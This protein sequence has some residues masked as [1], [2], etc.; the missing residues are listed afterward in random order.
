VFVSQFRFVQ[1][2]FYQLLHQGTVVPAD[3]IGVCRSQTPRTIVPTGKWSVSNHDEL[4]SNFFAQPDALACGLSEE[5][6][7][8]DIPAGLRPHK[9]FPGN[10]PSSSILLDCLDPAAIGSLLALYEHRT[11]V[12]GFAWGICS[13]DQWGVELGKKLGVKAR[14]ALAGARGDAAAP[15]KGDFNGSTKAL[16]AKYL[17]KSG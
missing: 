12:Q 9:V 7:P 6:L 5:E 1:H 17:A 3:F 15:I 10:R 4:M 8:A 14:L 13:F 11:A 2:S 16:M